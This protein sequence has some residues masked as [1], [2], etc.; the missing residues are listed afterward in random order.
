MISFLPFKEIHLLSLREWLQKNHI[1]KVWQESEDQ[2]ELKE[3]YLVKHPRRGIKSFVIDLGGTVIGYIQYYN[4]YKI[5][6]GW[7]ENEKPGT[8]G[9]DIM[10]GEESLLGQGLGTQIIKQFIEFLRS[11]EASVQSIIIDPEP[12][13]KRAIR[14]FE[15]AGFVKQSVIKTPNGLAQL[16]RLE[17]TENLV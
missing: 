3:K 2:N 9:I 14:S 12:E 7:W 4:A 11:Q 1:K 10:I 6:D 16:M 13:N 8:Y 17:F 15:K 5:G